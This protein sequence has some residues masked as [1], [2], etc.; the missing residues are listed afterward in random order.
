[1][2]SLQYI[3]VNISCPY[4]RNIGLRMDFEIMPFC[5]IFYRRDLITGVR[6]Q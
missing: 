3:R 5:D 6:N 1:M 4:Y 2:R